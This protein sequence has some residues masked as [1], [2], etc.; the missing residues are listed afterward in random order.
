MVGDRGPK[1][2]LVERPP[3][4]PAPPPHLSRKDNAMSV[5]RSTTRKML[6]GQLKLTEPGLAEMLEENGLLFRVISAMLVAYDLGT[7]AYLDQAATPIG[8]PST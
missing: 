6:L 7:E 8:K 5:S 4:S 3:Q 1:G 2:P